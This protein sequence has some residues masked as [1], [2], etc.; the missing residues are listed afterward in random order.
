MKQ[1]LLLALFVAG[2]SYCLQAQTLSYHVE[3]GGGVT[4]LQASNPDIKAKAGYKAGVYV[5][6]AKR[7]AYVELGLQ[8]AKKGGTLTGFIDRYTPYVRNADM[9]FHFIEMPLLIGFKITGVPLIVKYGVYGAYG[10]AGSGDVACA[11]DGTGALFDARIADAFQRETFTHAG[12]TYTYTPFRRWD[13]GALLALDVPYKRLTFRFVA[14]FGNQNI[15][16]EYDKRIAHRSA[17]LSV[18]YTL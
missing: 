8:Y 13:Y 16:S 1:H 11:A 4:E 6:Y 2:G 15:H 3:A 5:A 14:A 9:D 7:A 12:Q 18:A 17:L 10:V